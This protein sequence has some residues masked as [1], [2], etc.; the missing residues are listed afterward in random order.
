MKVQ[1]VYKIKKSGTNA[2]MG[3]SKNEFSDEFPK[4]KLYVSTNSVL[5]VYNELRKRGL[6]IEVEA[7]VLN[8]RTFDIS[9]L[10][11]EL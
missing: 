4:Q 10:M 11:D 3:Y 9:E 8:I 1:E 5:K 2:Y 6:D 7:F